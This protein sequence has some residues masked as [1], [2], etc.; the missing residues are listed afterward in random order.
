MSNLIGLLNG[1]TDRMDEMNQEELDD[2]RGLLSWSE[3]IKRILDVLT[4]ESLVNGAWS[5]D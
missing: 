4:V 1:V 3:K 5:D 2:L